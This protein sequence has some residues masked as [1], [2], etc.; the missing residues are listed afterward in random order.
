MW[1]LNQYNL[2]KYCEIYIVIFSDTLLQNVYIEIVSLSDKRNNSPAFWDL[3][4]NISC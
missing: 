1:Y 3:D 2:K 4:G